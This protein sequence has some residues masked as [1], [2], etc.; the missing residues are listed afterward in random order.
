MRA[1][2]QMLSKKIRFQ[3]SLVIWVSMLFLLLLSLVTAVVFLTADHAEKDRFESKKNLIHTQIGL[4]AKVFRDEVNALDDYLSNVELNEAI[5]PAEQFSAFFRVNKE[6]S[7][8]TFYTS[9]NTILPL[10]NPYSGYYYNAESEAGFNELL[11]YGDRYDY[12]LRRKAYDNGEYIQFIKYMPASYAGAPV[13]AV[14]EKN[15]GLL[16]NSISDIHFPEDGNLLMVNGMNDVLFYT[17]ENQPAY[18]DNAILNLMHNSSDVLADVKVGGNDYH[19]FYDRGTMFGCKAVFLIPSNGAFWTDAWDGRFY[20]NVLLVGA[21]LILISFCLFYKLIYKPVAGLERSIRIMA[22]DELI[23]ELDSPSSKLFEQVFMHLKSISTKLNRL[24]QNEISSKIL[25]KQTELFALQSQINPHF[26]YNTLET[27]RGQAI[28]IKATAIERM[29]KALAELFRYSIIHKGSMVC[30]KEELANVDNYLAI[31]QYRFADRFTYSKQIDE[32]ILNHRVPKLMLQ[33]LVENA[34]QH[35]LEKKVG[36]G[37]IM[38]RAHKT[39]GRLLIFI[40]DDGIGIPR[41]ELDH[42]NHGLAN[43]NQTSIKNRIGLSNVNERIK[44]NYGYEYGIKL[45]SETDKGTLVE[46]NLPLN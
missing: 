28:S 7:G 43:S 10:P 35:G 20:L 9:Q 21:A 41:E 44:L 33:P 46:I 24:S 11:Y 14:V 8:I 15:I 17:N 1:M 6:I 25:V 29:I 27:I 18:I 39:Q 4:A 2:L 16:K 12:L 30:L 45:Y 31:Q 36:E 38:L 5:D 40:E 32:D 19:I 42:I 34:F 37:R 22:G 3:T 26:L 13:I 23:V